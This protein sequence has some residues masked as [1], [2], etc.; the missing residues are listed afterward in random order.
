METTDTGRIDQA[1]VHVSAKY[2]ITRCKELI[3][4]FGIKT[5]FLVMDGD[6]CPLKA[7]ESQDR[8]QKRQQNLKEA[9]SFKAQ[10]QPYKAEEKY[11]GCIRIKLDFTKKVMDEVKTFFQGHRQYSDRIFIVWSPH[12]ADA[13][14][15]KLCLDKNADAV[16]TEDSD[17]LVYSAAAHVA[18]AVLFKLDGNSGNCD[19]ISMDFLLSPS[20]EELEK[21]SKSNNNNT[22]EVL[23]RNFALTCC[24]DDQFEYLFYAF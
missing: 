18:F 9:R 21:A 3:D 22:F 13:Q 23:I 11:R 15:T 7:D 19:R 20:I 5:I 14:L 8:D 12:E 6:R 17:V 1:C 16:I 24:P 2:I 10:R 4:C